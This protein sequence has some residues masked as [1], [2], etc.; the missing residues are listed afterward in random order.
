VTCEEKAVR[1][2]RS[3]ESEGERKEPFDNLEGMLVLFFLPTSLILKKRVD[4]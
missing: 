2:E 3:N 1:R 4:L